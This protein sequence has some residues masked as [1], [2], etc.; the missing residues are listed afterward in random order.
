MGKL[1]RKFMQ[2]GHYLF[3]NMR[4]LRD[5]KI[6]KRTLQRARRI[7]HRWIKDKKS[8]HMHR[9]P[10]SSLKLTE[11]HDTPW[12]TQLLCDPKAFSGAE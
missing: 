10:S 6:Y 8:R 11:K 3:F 9:Q 7:S 12:E 5:Y 2:D 1:Y 4:T